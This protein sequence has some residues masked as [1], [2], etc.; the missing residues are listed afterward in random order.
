MPCEQG[1]FVAAG[2]RKS[3]G[4]RGSL[5]WLSQAELDEMP[6]PAV[7]RLLTSHGQVLVACGRAW[8]IAM[9]WATPGCAILRS[10]R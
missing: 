9:R 2:H 8:S 4:M 3:V 7:L 10:W 5:V 1:F 6:E